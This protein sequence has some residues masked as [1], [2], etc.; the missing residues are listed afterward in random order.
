MQGDGHG[1]MDARIY[2]ETYVDTNSVPEPGAT[3]FT[4]PGSAAGEESAPMEVDGAE[5]QFHRGL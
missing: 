1:M 4:A 3:E 5:P 2:S